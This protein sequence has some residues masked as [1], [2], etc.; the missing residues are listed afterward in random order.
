M[1][2]TFKIVKGHDRVEN[3]MWFQVDTSVRTTKSVADPLNLRSQ[4]ARLDPRRHFL[5]NRVVDGWNL[6][7]SEIQNARNAHCFKIAYRNHRADMV[8]TA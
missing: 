6:A 2:Q 3:T 8:G 1:L 7:P 4:T 5:S